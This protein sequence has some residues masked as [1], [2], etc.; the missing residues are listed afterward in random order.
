MILTQWQKIIFIENIIHSR[1]IN[2]Y[3]KNTIQ[4]IYFLGNE[5]AIVHAYKT[6]KYPRKNIKYTNTKRLTHTT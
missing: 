4:L 2:Y 1:L 6:L 3:I 5:A